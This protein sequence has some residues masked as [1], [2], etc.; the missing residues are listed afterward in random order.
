LQ[1]LIAFII[2]ANVRIKFEIWKGLDRGEEIGNSKK[3]NIREIAIWTLQFGNIFVLLPC[4]SAHSH[5]GIFVQ[6][7]SV[8]DRAFGSSPSEKVNGRN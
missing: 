7:A 6:D 4:F 5:Y 1:I 8:F 3:Q 2:V